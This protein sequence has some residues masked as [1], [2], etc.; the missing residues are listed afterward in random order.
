M[1]R[2][3][4]DSDGTNNDRLLMFQ[5]EAQLSTSSAGVEGKQDFAFY[6]RHGMECCMQPPLFF[7]GE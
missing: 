5:N 1:F 7:D 2:H 6:S 3:S 4:I